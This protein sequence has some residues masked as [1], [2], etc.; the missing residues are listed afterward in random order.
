MSVQ[1]R[2]HHLSLVLEEYC[3]GTMT[4]D[5]SPHYYQLLAVLEIRQQEL[6]KGDRYRY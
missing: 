5:L 1:V 6:M 2:S 3:N 4:S